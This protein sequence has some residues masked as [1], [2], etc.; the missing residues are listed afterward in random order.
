MSDFQPQEDD[1]AGGSFTPGKHGRLPYFK[2]FED[3]EVLRR[4]NDALELHAQSKGI[5]IPNNNNFQKG[6]DTTNLK[7]RALIVAEV[8]GLDVT[9]WPVEFRE[10][11]DKVEDWLIVGQ[12]P[13]SEDLITNLTF[14]VIR[15]AA[16]WYRERAGK[17]NWEGLVHSQLNAVKRER[18]RIHAMQMGYS[19][20]QTPE[21][22]IEDASIVDA[23]DMHDHVRKQL[24]PDERRLFDCLL[25]VEINLS[26]ASRQPTARDVNIEMAYQMGWL[27]QTDY[28]WYQSDRE[29]TERLDAAAKQCKFALRKLR[30]KRHSAMTMRDTASQTP[31][32]RTEGVGIIDANGMHEDVLQRIDLKEQRLYDCHKQVQIDLKSEAGAKQPTAKEV[33]IETAYRMGWL[34]QADHERHRSRQ[35]NPEFYDRLKPAVTRVQVSR[36]RLRDKRCI[37]LRKQD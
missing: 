2:F 35:G 23:M 12:H 9:C 19:A 37:I 7:K 1:D 21:R 26:S 4:I 8:L 13:Q 34:S 27:S 3:F 16:R 5:E 24:N 11:W 28:A 31:V 18:D 22:R 25:R 30:D 10:M 6:K 33:N 29:L 17:R 15:N 32:C 14:I 20:G 36:S